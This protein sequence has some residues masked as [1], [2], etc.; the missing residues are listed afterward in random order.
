MKKQETQ[1]TVAQYYKVDPRNIVLL[2]SLLEAHEGFLLFRTVD[3][4]EGVIELL[5]SPDFLDEVHDVL[6]D[7]SGKIWM[8][9]IP[10]PVS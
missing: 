2:K 6:Y 10:E 4:K 5:V 9:R 3:P 8:E 1:D 7:L